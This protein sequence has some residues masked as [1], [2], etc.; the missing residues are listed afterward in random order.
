MHECTLQEVL[1]QTIMKALV[2][3]CVLAR[4][5]ANNQYTHS[6]R[7][8]IAFDVYCVCVIIVRAIDERPPPPFNALINRAM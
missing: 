6:G 8:R 2:E 5:R 3:Q 4:V 1:I 7:S